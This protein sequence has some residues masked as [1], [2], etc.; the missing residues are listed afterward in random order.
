MFLSN[1]T[2]RCRETRLY[3][4]LARLLHQFYRKRVTRTPRLTTHHDKEIAMKNIT[5]LLLISLG[6]LGCNTTRGLG[7]DIEA[8]GESIEEAAE[9]AKSKKNYDQD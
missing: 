4:P 1:W 9:N 5:I 2:R 6:L 7:Q 3:A 8:V